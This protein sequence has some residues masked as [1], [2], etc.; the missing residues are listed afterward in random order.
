MIRLTPTKDPEVILK[1]CRGPAILKR[2]AAG[3]NVDINQVRDWIG[4]TKAIFV[5]AHEENK[6]LGFIMFNPESNGAYSI[7]VCLRTVKEKTKKIIALGLSYA[8]YV[9]YAQEINAVYPKAY[10][11]VALLAN[12]F[13]FRED[14]GLQ[15]FYKVPDGIPFFFQRL[16]LH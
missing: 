5:V 6:G 7:H 4:K 15:K 3:L 2:C 9:L 12:H 13:G 1:F 16:D 14:K 10:K 11:S 8:Q